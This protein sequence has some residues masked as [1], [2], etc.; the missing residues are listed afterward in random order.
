MSMKRFSRPA[1]DADFLHTEE[2][3]RNVLHGLFVP[4]RA[5]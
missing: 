3:R 5:A 4:L 2:R 1:K